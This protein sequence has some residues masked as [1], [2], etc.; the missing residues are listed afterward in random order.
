MNS[1]CA[2]HTSG[3]SQIQYTIQYNTIQ[4]QLF[5][6]T[7]LDRHLF[8]SLI[9]PRSSSLVENIFME[10][11]GVACKTFINPILIPQKRMA[12]VITFKDRKHHSKGQNL[13]FSLNLRNIDM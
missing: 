8:F 2:L 13:Y 10:V 4:L 11:W 3:R 7:L 12:R 5:F 6:F 1:L 9:T